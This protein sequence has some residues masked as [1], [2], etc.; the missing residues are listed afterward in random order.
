[1][2]LTAVFRLLAPITE[3]Q[4]DTKGNVAWL[5]AETPAHQA[6]QAHGGHSV[7][8]CPG[9]DWKRRHDHPHNRRRPVTLCH[10]TTG[11]REGEAYN[12]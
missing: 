1:M 9:Y 10:L 3:E 7:D 5:S 12:W 2:L 6:F 11:Q 4:G 8:R